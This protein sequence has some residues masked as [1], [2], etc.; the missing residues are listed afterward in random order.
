MRRRL[1]FLWLTVV[2]IALIFSAP[3]VEG[4]KSKRLMALLALALLKRPKKLILPLP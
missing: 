4:G 1:V 2:C 3:T